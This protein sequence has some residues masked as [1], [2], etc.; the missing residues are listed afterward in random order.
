MKEVID[1]LCSDM[2]LG[3]ALRLRE[4][5]KDYDM[6]CMRKLA[7]IFMAYVICAFALFGLIVAC[8]YCSGEPVDAD[9]MERTAGLMVAIGGSLIAGVTLTYQSLG[10]LV[11][12]KVREPID[13]AVEYL[14]KNELENDNEQH[15]DG[16]E[17]E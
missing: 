3:K 7:V 10:D 5:L 16:A 15:T 2:T 8:M 14:A 11:R 9:W 13:D 4:T 1:E 6:R 12:R 17:V